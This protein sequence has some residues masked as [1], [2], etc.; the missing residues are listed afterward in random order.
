M[1]LVTIRLTI[2][3]ALAFVFSTTSFCQDELDSALAVEALK[4]VSMPPRKSTPVAVQSQDDF[5][6][7]GI[8]KLGIATTQT[9]N[10]FVNK[11]N[12]G[13]KESVSL[14][15]TYKAQSS[16]GNTNTVLL[17]RKNEKDFYYTDPK[18]IDHPDVKVYYVNS[19]EVSGVK[20]KQLYLQFYKDTLYDFECDYSGELIDAI[21]LKYG[22]GLD[23]S[24]TKKLQCTG[25]LA[26]N[27]EVEESYHYEKWFSKDKKIEATACIGEYYNSE[28]IK[29]PLSYFIIQNPRINEKVE[30]EA[31]KIK[32]AKDEKS[33]IEKRAKLSDF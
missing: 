11:N 16:Y 7:I 20:L 13:I 14:M 28:C 21:K 15:D 32:S 33:N 4:E 17:L 8:F 2:T 10:D 24:K 26:G 31:D 18:Y 25:R 6:G 5:R 30:K 12:L 1:K 19:Y 9:L 29:K 22:E 23:S 27:F 3:F